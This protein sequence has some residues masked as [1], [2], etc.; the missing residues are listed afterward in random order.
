M[1]ANNILSANI[2]DILY[3][4]RN[5]EYGAYQLRITYDRRIF[6][7]LGVT[8]I[9]LIIVCISVTLKTS[10]DDKIFKIVDID[11]TL[12]K[13]DIEKEKIQPA[14]KLPEA[15]PIKTL[16]YVPPII[17]KDKLVIEPPVKVE[18]LVD[19]RI[20]I[21]NLEGKIDDGSISPPK[22]IINSQ[23]LEAP[24]KAATDEDLPF[25]K[26]EIEAKFKGDWNSYVKKEMEKNI[27]ELT[28]AGESGTCVVKFIVSK[29]GRVSDVEAITMKG[30]KLAEVAVNTIRK[31]PN[32]IPAQQN[33]NEVK[34]YRQQ[35]ITFKIQD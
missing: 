11:V 24:K 3:E 26:V 14:P 34:A 20:D 18:E 19:A 4:G 22:E 5:K 1:E 8:A 16:A 7:S 31:G 25:Y 13:K 29:D 2:L 23:V 21:K 27:D 9:A 15:K 17:V 30:T 12:S 32:W 28:E 33:G 35:P 6:S 10:A